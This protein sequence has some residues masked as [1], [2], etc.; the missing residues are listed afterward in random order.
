LKETAGRRE[1]HAT[2]YFVLDREHCCRDEGSFLN[3]LE[4]IETDM[5]EP[6]LLPTKL[7]TMVILILPKWKITSPDCCK[8]S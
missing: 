6:C 4:M 2:F 8:L 7:G 3:A 1:Q 5:K